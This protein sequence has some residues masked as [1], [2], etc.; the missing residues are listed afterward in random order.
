MRLAGQNSTGEVAMTV[1]GHLAQVQASTT[2]SR[3]YGEPYETPAGTTVI[4]VARV[5]GRGLTATP[6]GV[7]AIHE[8]TVTW[9]PAVDVTRIAFLGEFIG[10]AAAV[11][12]TL[13]VLRR[14]PWPDLSRRSGAGRRS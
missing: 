11:I 3:V 7:F 14:P 13:A 12:A 10:L 4:P 2:G 5:S 8:G 6:V 1:R 9:E